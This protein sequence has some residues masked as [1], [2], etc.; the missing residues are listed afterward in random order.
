MKIAVTGASGHVGNNL[1]RKLSS[2]GHNLKGLKHHSADSLKNVEMQ[3]IEGDVL[4]P[5]SLNNLVKD[6]EVVFHLAA[7]IDLLGNKKS[8][9]TTIVEGTKNIIE[10]CIRNN[11]R[12]LIHFST[13]H[14]IDHSNN[15]SP[16]DENRPLIS[17]SRIM[18]ETSKAKAEKLIQ[19]I[20]TEIL[21]TIVLNP[22]AI[23]G[24]NDFAPSMSGQLI[25]QL[26]SNSIPAII[27]GGYNWVD[28]RDVV[29]A[30]CNATLKGVPGKRYILSGKWHSLKEIS[31][32][33]EELTGNNTPKLEMP[34]FIAWL[35]LPFIQA[36]S[37]FKKEQPLYTKDSLMVVAGSS[38]NIDNSKAKKHLDFKPRPLKDTIRDTIQ[39]FDQYKK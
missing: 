23:M 30:A 17:K 25:R 26:R 37:W 2:L 7:K 22:T 14:A 31:L 35:G 6:A 32:M 34:M 38:R 9:F 39:W 19:D 36:M 4:I 5:N 3:L 24:P 11:V 29:N 13:I 18:Y 1:C 27:P 15:T 20:P 33:V 21:E 12:R 8:M 10:A 28:V 16:L